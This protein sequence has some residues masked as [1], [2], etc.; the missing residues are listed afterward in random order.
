[1]ASSG[2]LFSQTLQDITNTKLEELTKKR[3]HFED[4]RKAL[5]ANARRVENPVEALSTLADGVKA[6][7]S[8]SVANGRVVRG[9]TDKPRLEIDLKNLDRFLAQARYDPSVSTQVMNQWRQSLLRHLEI[10]SLKFSYASL[11]GQLTTEWLSSKQTPVKALEGED[12]E[13]E[14][15][16]HLSGGKKMESRMKWERSVF[17][18]AEVDETA[19][20][21]MLSELFEPKEEDRK[22]LLKA[23]KA[24]RERVKEFARELTSPGNF[25]QHTLDW[26]ISGL[27]SSDLLADE[28]KDVLR[29]FQGNYVILNEIADVLN[30]RMAA[31]DTWSWGDEV[32]LEE[33]RQLNGSF[34]IYMHEDLLQ[35]IFL[36]YIGVKW[37][38]FW[39][40][41]IAN[42]RKFR[43]VWNSPR[44]SI[45]LIDRKRRDYYLGTQGRGSVEAEKQKIY[46][47]N[48][49]LSQ[50]LD[51]ETQ[52]VVGA[53]G[54]EEA[55][56]EEAQFYQQLPKTRT[57][58]TAPRMAPRMQM[59]SKPARQGL[60]RGGAMRHRKIAIEEEGDTDS[61]FDDEDSSSSKPKN[62]MENKQRLLHL[63][64]TDILIKTR[65]HG[66]ITCFRSQLESFY[67]SLPHAT[68]KAVFSFFGVPEKW[69]LFFKRFLEAPLRFIDEKS[70]Q[71][72]LRKRG[73]PGSHT[74][75][76]VFGEVVLFC[77]DFQVNQKTAG[78]TLWRLHD[79]F[80]FWSS[81][82]A[83]CADA[84]AVVTHFTQT[85]GMTL[86]QART[87]SA[88]MQRK[89]KHEGSGSG[90]ADALAAV[91][92][93]KPLPSGQVRWG[94]LALNPASGRF[95]I[96]QAMVDQHI[97]E[98][99]RQ[100]AD[101]TRSVFAWI[102][103]W[104]T[105]ASTFF[106]SNF[107]KPANCFGRQH[108]DNMLATHE[109]LQR[110]IFSD[111]TAVAAE[112]SAGS[113]SV[114]AFLKGAIE[115]R[116]GVQD[117]PD[118]Y[119]FFPVELG[120][121]EVQSPFIGLLQIRDA[122][123]E[124]PALRLDAFEE[125]ERQAYREVK[126]VFELGKL[127]DES[128]REWPSFKP[129][130]PDT[131][132]PLEEYTRYR[133]EVNYHFNG[134]LRD[135][136]LELLRCPSEESLDYDDNGLVKMAL[137]AL[138]NQ[139]SLRGILADW[140]SMEPYWKWVAH[141][142][143]PEM[144]ERFGGFNIV[145]PG[146]LPIGMVSLFRSGGVKWQE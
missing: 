142:Y 80:W 17:E 70:A 67:P 98:L 101:K 54:D 81:N 41:T 91:S 85:T 105:Y 132:M 143:G 73:T 60:G 146:L 35:A 1:M 103:A 145:D 57:K 129:E 99:S 4:H 37:S 64:A 66:E 137:N 139:T 18:A 121:L 78:Q 140:Y 36:Q 104:N 92:V 61:E 82:H 128:T 19:I 116:F 46:R 79:D 120:G 25:T 96:D 2:S 69:L 130:D 108:V 29:D 44:K 22:R 84:W 7:F 144:I 58:Q 111:S 77:L 131:F 107:G 125:D 42:F 21:Q 27:L 38:V 89:Q 43:G 95:E 118:G 134:E 124:R 26:T 72:R 50:L 112:G 47:Q 136:F 76:E 100:L 138:G 93:D 113:G 133:E 62:P 30:M 53:E 141:L 135:V 102:Q 88:R 109:R 5:T 15:F 114:A 55:D 115:Q 14:D 63:L 94:M 10:Q 40:K 74:L 110:R 9:S 16:E 106:T 49:F 90:S 23:L 34:N 31:L 97:G 48:Y 83:T 68:I 117:I 51:T 3:D 11:Y 20:T 75:S 126:A 8:V 39:K 127:R 45:P 33:R 32:Q 123:L 59:A 24:L 6:C 65:I 52:E 87:G 122:V 28:M 13:M 56:F 12:T 71:P 86:N 119:L